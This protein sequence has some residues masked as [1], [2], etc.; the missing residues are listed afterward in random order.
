MV[1]LLSRRIKIFCKK[2]LPYNPNLATGKAM[3]SR[4]SCCT[5]LKSSHF[6]LVFHV[7]FSF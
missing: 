7:S 3:Y 5:F 6:K 1:Q 2:V 4:Q